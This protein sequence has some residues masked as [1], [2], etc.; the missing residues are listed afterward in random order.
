MRTAT[1]PQIQGAAR[2]VQR[3]HAFHHGRNREALR[4]N[5]ADE[6]IVHVEVHDR[7]AHSDDVRLLTVK[8]RGRPAAPDE[9]R[10]CTLS[11]STRGD[12]TDSH[13]P[14]QRLLEVIATR[15]TQKKTHAAIIKS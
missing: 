8:L 4:P 13:E 2:G 14:L 7:L 6:S 3:T 10:G 9:S 11:S 5:A 15:R 1:T 12:T